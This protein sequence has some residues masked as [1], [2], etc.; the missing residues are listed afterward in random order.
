[1]ISKNSQWHHWLSILWAW[2][3]SFTFAICDTCHT[4]Y[5]RLQWFN[6]A[7][8]Y[9]GAC[10][11]YGCTSGA[12]STTFGRGST[13]WQFRFH[14]EVA[15]CEHSVAD[16]TSRSCVHEKKYMETQ[17]L[18]WPFWTFLIDK[19]TYI[20]SRFAVRYPP[21]P[22]W[23][24]PKT[25]VLQHSAWKRCICSVFC[26]VGCWRGPKPANSLDFC[27][28]PSEN[29]LFAMFWLRHRGVVRPR[30]LLFLCQID[31]IVI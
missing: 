22:T 17:H 25:C 30:P 9:A 13:I 20:W 23:Y 26:M 8:L 3:L 11:G 16:A 10:A 24:G 1:M 15:S 18:F 31:Q 6:A 2:L 21:P 28:Q 14:R 12:T 29:V 19:Y 4:G 7:T 5:T 27:N